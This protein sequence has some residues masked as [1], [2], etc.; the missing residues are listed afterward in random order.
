[1][2]PSPWL[3]T[4]CT[5]LAVALACGCG[6]ARFVTQEPDGGIV[7]MPSDTP[8][9]RAAAA[10]LMTQQCPQGYV[11]ERE[12]VVSFNDEPDPNPRLGPFL[13]RGAKP[14]HEYRLTFHGK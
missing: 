9:N 10:E 2:S 8:A 13:N 11:V 12:D 1:M 3:R 5:G 6:T 14:T 4:F 7:A